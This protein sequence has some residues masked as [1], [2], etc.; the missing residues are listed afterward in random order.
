MASFVFLLGFSVNAQAIEVTVDDN[1][2]DNML[3][4]EGQSVTGSFDINPALPTD[5]NY[6]LPYDVVDAVASFSFTD[7]NDVLHSNS[8]TLT[9]YTNWGTCDGHQYQVQTT[10]DY[11]V[12]ENDEVQMTMGAQFSSDG[13]TWYQLEVLDS[14]TSTVNTSS[15]VHSYSYFCG[16]STWGCDTCTGHY[17]HYVY[18]HYENIN[19][20]VT[21]G[22]KGQ[23]TLDVVL[24]SANL[25][26]LS[27]DGAIDFTVTGLDGDIVFNKGLLTADINENPM[28]APVPEPAT[29]TLL[30][31]GLAGLFG[32]SR[33]KRKA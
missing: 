24:D 8:Q 16:C 13:T 7:D 2:A 28:A 27:L 1:L 30:G 15:H 21:S 19:Y 23:L 18:T 14:Q 12:D 11:F 10:Y 3:I 20:D 32:A 4:A 33:K 6:N 31:M 9:T 26:D 5:G 17:T 29:L 25:A 22:Y